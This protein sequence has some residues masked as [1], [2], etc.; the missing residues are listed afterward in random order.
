MMHIDNFSNTISIP[1][2]FSFNDEYSK[3]FGV[4]LQSI[5]DNSSQDFKYNI[6]ALVSDVSED[7]KDLLL[8]MLPT[9]FNLTFW[10]INKVIPSEFKNIE[11]FETQY[12]T[13][14]IYYRLFIPYL[15]QGYEKVLYLD[16]DVVVEEDIKNLNYDLSRAQIMAALDTIVPYLDE[17]PA[18]VE[19]MQNVLGLEHPNN[20]CN[21][22]VILF[23]LKNIDLKDYTQKLKKAFQIKEL[24][25]PDQDILNQ[26]FQ[27]NIKFLPRKWNFNS[28]PYI[29]EGFYKKISGDFEADFLEAKKKPSLIHFTSQWKPWNHTKCRNYEKFWKYA[30][31]TAFYEEILAHKNTLGD[32]DLLKLIELYMKIKNGEKIL[33]WGASIFLTNFFKLTKLKSDNIIG[34]IDINEEKIGT[35]LNG[36]PIYSPNKIKELNPKEI[37]ITIISNNCKKSITEELSNQKINVKLSSLI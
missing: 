16:S 5:I 2:V 30:R 25:F 8:D 20:Y 7:N 27:N 6:F 12:Y 1:I 26:I 17:R 18:R 32:I 15:F 13:K 24:L 19:H 36:Y 14:D 34:I 23:N 4:A 21:S 31:K 9:N 22:G 3:F 37:I 33:L 11:L 35:E 10:D 28:S 29:S